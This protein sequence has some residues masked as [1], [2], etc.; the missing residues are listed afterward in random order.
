MGRVIVK[1]ST[2]PKSKTQSLSKFQVSFA[3]MENPILK[4]IR[5]GNGS[6]RAKTILTGGKKK[7]K[8][9]EVVR[10]TPPNFKTYY[11]ST[12]MISVGAA[13]GSFGGACD[14]GS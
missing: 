12:A 8:K 13:G 5:N 10:L 14:S 6:Q 1:V 11:K 2:P 4:F 3:E 9:N 7:K